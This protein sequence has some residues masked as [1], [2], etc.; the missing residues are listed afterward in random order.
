MSERIIN[1]QQQYEPVFGDARECKNDHV[2]SLFYMIRDG[3]YVRNVDAD[4]I[5]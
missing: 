3:D 4:M 5:I 1:Y 2:A